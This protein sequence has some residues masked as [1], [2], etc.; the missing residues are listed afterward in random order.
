ME[1]PDA[2]VLKEAKR[3]CPGGHELSFNTVVRAE[4]VGRGSCANR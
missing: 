4:R 1:P 2:I 3:L